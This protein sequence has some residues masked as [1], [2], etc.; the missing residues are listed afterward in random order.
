MAHP[1]I[2]QNLFIVPKLILGTLW[3]SHRHMH[4]VAKLFVTQCIC[5]Q[6]DSKKATLCLLVWEMTR[7]WRMEGEAHCSSGSSGSRTSGMQTESPLWHV[8]WGSLNQA[9][10]H[11]QGTRLEYSWP[12]CHMIVTWFS[13]VETIMEKIMNS[14]YYIVLC[15]IFTRPGYIICLFVFSKSQIFLQYYILDTWTLKYTKFI[16]M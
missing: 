1:L 16:E 7:G 3:Q 13:H 8:C 4:K 10:E 12:I 9:T 11:P 6:M 2:G 14:F 15:S 5:S